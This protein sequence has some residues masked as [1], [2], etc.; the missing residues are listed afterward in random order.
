MPV[1]ISVPTLVIELAI[2]LLMVFVLERW[3]FAP[4]RK[5]WAE[6]D[7]LIQEGLQATGTG[8]EEIEQAREEV[9]Q[10]LTEARRQAQQEVDQATAQA[11]ALR[12]QMVA[13]ATA[14]FRRLVDTAR[15]EIAAERESTAAALRDRVVDLALL[16]ASQVTGQSYREPAVRELAAAVVQR[17]G[18]S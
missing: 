15:G 10:I 9:R 17:E 16:A 12:D 2:F 4:I 1:S 6:R 7:R 8:R 3:V 13:Q 11:D 14:E 18:L 5:A